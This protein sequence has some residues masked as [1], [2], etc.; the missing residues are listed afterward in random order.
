MQYTTGT[1]P[2]AYLYRG[3]QLDTDLNLYY[4]RARYFDPLSGRFLTQDP[5]NGDPTD[6]IS[7]HRYLY[8]ASDPVAKYDPSGRATLSPAPIAPPEGLVG[9]PDIPGVQTPR[10]TERQIIIRFVVGVAAVATSGRNGDSRGEVVGRQPNVDRSKGIRVGQETE[11]YN[12]R[13]R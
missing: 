7:L 9:D 2:N 10:K 1:T 12:N 8:A 13:S 6:P 11:G 5:E 3:E 4:L